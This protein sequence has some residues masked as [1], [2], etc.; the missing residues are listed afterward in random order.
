MQCI[1]NEIKMFFRKRKHEIEQE[2][3]L[4]TPI[5]NGSNTFSETIPD[6]SESFIE[7]LE[8]QDLINELQKAI[9]ILS[10]KEKD[11]ISMY[12]GFKGT[13]I[14]QGEIAKQL[15]VTQSRISRMIKKI[16]LK[17]KEELIKI[18]MNSNKE[19][20]NTQKET[21]NQQ[22]I[23]E[24][25]MTIKDYEKVLELISSPKLLEIIEK[26]GRDESIILLLKF[27]Y[28]NNTYFSNKSIME[29]FNIEEAK[30]NE[31]YK[32]GLLIYRIYLDYY[33]NQTLKLTE[34]TF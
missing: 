29:F 4:D 15:G 27:G 2:V 23:E 28:I 26:Y 32:K 17:L 24:T 33:L 9:E 13:P 31:V 30:I 25:D 20:T 21:K 12:F 5:N 10:D 22:F 8:D 19:K 34:K 3:S 16:I 1:H 7:K 11:I 18:E 14:S 6:D